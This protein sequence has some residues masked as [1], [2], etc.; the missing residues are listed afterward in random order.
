MRTRFHALVL[1]LF[2]GLGTL[3]AIPTG[4]AEPVDAKKVAKLIERLGGD[5]FN[6]REK[7]SAEL[8]A[9]GAPALEA[10]RKATQDKDV[11]ISKRAAD[12][13][14]KIE[15]RTEAGKILAPKK[16][17]LVYRDMPVTEALADFSKKTGYAITLLDPENKVKDRK[18]SLDTGDV[19]FWQAFEMFC[20]EA[21]L[22]E[23]DLQGFANANP[24]IRPLPINR[25][26]INPRP[27]QI[28]PVPPAPP[29]K[30]GKEPGPKDEGQDGRT[31]PQPPRGFGAPQPAQARALPGAAPVQVIGAPVPAPGGIGVVGWGFNGGITN[32]IIVTDG[33]ARAL[34]AD[35]S[36]SIRVR[37][38]E[39]PEIFGPADEKLILLGLEL[40]PEPKMHIL[41]VVN[42]K[43]DK[44][45]DD[46]D[47]SLVQSMVPAVNPN[48]PPVFPGAAPG[49][50]PAIARLP[51]GFLFSNITPVYLKKGEKASKSLK[52]LT[53]V[54]S[55][56]IL[57]PA[58]PMITVEK[59]MDAAGKEVKGDAGGRIKVLEVKQDANGQI[60][61][62]FEM[63]QPQDVMPANPFG[64][65]NGP[66]G[67][68]GVRIMPAPIKLPPG[69]L[70]PAPPAPKGPGPDFKADPPKEAPPQPPQAQPAQIQVQI[71]VAPGAPPQV[72]QI[73][74]GGIGA[75]AF[76]PNQNGVTL[77]DE[78]GNSVQVIGSNVNFR[79]EAR[80]N[81]VLEHIMIFQPEKDQKPAKLVFSGS[82]TVTIDIPFTLKNVPLP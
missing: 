7:A 55:A 69:A 15:K 32:Q 75:P 81:A 61:V 30:E 67:V 31:A 25:V 71:Q 80:G 4:A 64:P 79:R 62:K 46:K 77:E 66:F 10:L 21:G 43:V 78:K 39:K 65:V 41:H 58:R 82:K 60:T 1:V 38:L 37:A 42:V 27:I 68:P 48:V 72:I 52:E 63:E 34:P 47:Q 45:V 28:Q 23:T 8:D 20:K 33:K 17:H 36:G 35:N 9:I 50:A 44:A 13:V 51:H 54:V 14:G 11:E 19:T 3:I 56:E 70:P 53:G 5:D 57:A 59:I 73:G 12:L 26:P 76:F 22:A 18:M 49:A 24:I 16:V 74:R 2:L 6:D 29:Q 40:T